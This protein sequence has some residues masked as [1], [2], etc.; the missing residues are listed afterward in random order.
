MKTLGQP[1]E[2]N[3]VTDNYEAVGDGRLLIVGAAIIV[4]FFGGFV[5]WAGL[6]PLDSAAIAN[7]AVRIES[8]RKV[9]QH[10]EGGIIAEIK[11]RDGDIVVAGQTLVRLDD[12]QTRA[13]LQLVQGR[14][15][16]ALALEARLVAER[17]NAEKIQFPKELL[18]QAPKAEVRDVMRG[19]SNI[20]E[21]RRRAITGQTA[22]LRKR[23]SILRREIQGRRAMVKAQD[24]MR[25]LAREEI[26]DVAKLLRTGLTK[27]A[28]LLALQSR[29]AE[30][31]GNRGENLATVAGAEQQI[32][33]TRLRINELGTAMINEIVQ[34][35]QD[36]QQEIFDLKERIRS[37]E[38]LLTRTEI[39][40]QVSGTVVDLRYHTTGGV[41][42]PGDAILD[43]VPSGDKLVIEARVDPKYIGHL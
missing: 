2:S 24:K 8:S 38:D 22:I 18:D 16:A 1:E 6:A 39:K 21:A 36:I 25:S 19:Q 5:V 29:E 4:A 31:E 15:V 32:E 11:V 40:A 28:R 41:I 37:A 23:I 13:R 14:L 35:L 20:F 26:T 43:I 30:I 9:I 3:K 7:G 12:T 10:L 34:Q 33:E 17:D 42:G 27:K